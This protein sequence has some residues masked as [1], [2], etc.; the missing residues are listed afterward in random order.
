MF[1]VLDEKHEGAISHAE[2]TET[3]YELIKGRMWMLAEDE[4]K[5]DKTNK[6]KQMP[7]QAAVA[8]AI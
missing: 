4:D 6:I 8:E 3:V 7:S 5:S 1:D 2:V